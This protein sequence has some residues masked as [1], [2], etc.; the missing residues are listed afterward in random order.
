MRKSTFDSFRVILLDG[1]VV[2]RGLEELEDGEDKVLLL[3]VSHWYKLC[4]VSRV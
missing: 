4:I 1:S 3:F 2:E